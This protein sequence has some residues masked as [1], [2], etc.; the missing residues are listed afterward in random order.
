VLC[1]HRA[2]HAGH[3]CCSDSNATRHVGF[4]KTDPHLQIRENSIHQHASTST[5]Q[6]NNSQLKADD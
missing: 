1:L 2:V 3:D 6:H 4:N 5:A